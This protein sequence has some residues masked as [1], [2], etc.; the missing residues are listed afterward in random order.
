M[1]SYPLSTSPFTISVGK[2]NVIV[3]TARYGNS[4]VTRTSDCFHNFRTYKEYAPI[5][6]YTGHSEDVALF[7][8]EKLY[9]GTSYPDQLRAFI[10]SDITGG[11]KLKNLLNNIINNQYFKKVVIDY[12]LARIIYDISNNKYYPNYYSDYSSDLERTGI[13]TRDIFVLDNLNGLCKC[14]NNRGLL[15]IIYLLQNTQF[16]RIDKGLPDNFVKAF[17]FEYAKRRFSKIEFAYYIMDDV[18]VNINGE[19][20]IINNLS[21]VNKIKEIVEANM[22]KE[23]ETETP[24]NTTT[25]DTNVL[26]TISY[27]EIAQGKV[28]KTKYN[29]LL[30]PVDIQFELGFRYNRIKYNPI[31]DTLF[32]YISDDIV[33]TD[34]FIAEL[35]NLP[36][37]VVVRPNIPSGIER[38]Y[39]EYSGD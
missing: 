37:V 17:L 35:V 15:Q 38:D 3:E 10:S 36:N 32:V 18:V 5:R 4:S 23:K 31:T 29:D 7:D 19:P 24:A 26:D 14:T 30:Y 12:R 20:S 22:S 13:T 33:E 27:I 34:E 39:S 21:E 8:A 1:S 25:T 9:L 16:I 11:N 28:D 6:F 2:K